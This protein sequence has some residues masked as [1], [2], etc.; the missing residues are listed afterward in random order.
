MQLALGT[1][2]F[3]L[4]YGIA[5]RGC[6]VP[7]NEVRAILEQAWRRGVRTLDTAAAYGDIEQRLGRLIEGLPFRVISKIP[8]IPPELSDAAAGCWAVDQAQRS[9]KRLG[10]ALD[11]VM[12]HRAEDLK[13]ERG[14]V[15]WREL[16]AWGSGE[17]IRLGASCYEPGTCLELLREHGIALAQ[18]PG[19]ALDQRI[20][21]EIPHTRAEL[22]IHLRSVFLQ[23]L[24]LMEAEA[25]HARLPSA[26]D[27]IRTWQ[28]WCR[29]R[30]L[31]PL[32]AALSLVRSFHAISFIV[33]G[34]DSEAQFVEIAKAWEEA[35]VIAAP[36][37][38]CE[39]LSII[40]PRLWN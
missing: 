34:V 6:A 4:A 37:L 32:S 25:V 2:Q 21:R 18:L 12:L 33:V 24:L 10:A 23:G 27:A 26:T 8:A 28:L 29:Q 36:E 13:G 19:N 5:G 20:A 16:Q 40:D 30:N 15:V 17:S 39:N 3:G 14:R 38:A 7:E 1:V 9:R 22:E 31:S 35:S 11:R